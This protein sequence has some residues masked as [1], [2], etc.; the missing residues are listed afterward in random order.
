ME[1]V[2]FFKLH[3]NGGFVAQIEVQYREKKTDGK[4]NISYSGEWKTWQASGYRDICLGAERTVDLYGD[5]GKIP[6]EAQV[7]LNAVVVWGKDHPSKEQ[8]IYSREYSKMAEY[9]IWGTT[10]CNKME[11]RSYR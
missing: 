5:I 2:R 1:K 3:N 9:E 10:L 4:G 6:E 8:Y 11:R 7:R